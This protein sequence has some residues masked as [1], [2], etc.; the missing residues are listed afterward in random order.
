VETREDIR[1]AIDAA[2]TETTIAHDSQRSVK[3]G[4]PFGASVDAPTIPISM[5]PTPT[6]EYRAYHREKLLTKGPSSPPSTAT[7]PTPGP[8][9]GPIP[10]PLPVLPGSRTL[11][12]KQDPS[13]TAIGIRPVYL[14]RRPATGP[15][16]ARITSQGLPPVTA[17]AMGDFVQTPGTPDF[18]AV[19]TFTVVRQ[20]LT[21]CQRSL[22]GLNLPWQWNTGGNTDPLS[23][24]ARGF[25]GANAFYSRTQKALK[26]GFF[27]KPGAPPAPPPPQIFTCRS[28][29]IV[30]HEAGHAILDGLKPGWI[31]SPHPQT[32][33]LHEA[34]GDEMA[35]FL[36][37]AQLDQVEAI[38]VQ[39]K[40]NLHD[41][42]FLSDMA[43]EFGLAL[44]RPNGLRNADNNLKLSEVSTEVHAISQVMTGAV[45]DILADIF[46]FENNPTKRDDAAVLLEVAQYVF[47]LVL[48]AH[49]AAPNANATFAD[50][51]N[52]MLKIA[53]A[54]GKPAQYRTFI[55]NQFTR[56]EVVV[57]ATPLTGGDD[58]DAEM[59]AVVVHDSSAVGDRRR[60]CGTMKSP[61]FIGEAERLAEE[62]EELRGDFAANSAGEVLAHLMS[63]D[64]RGNGRAASP[65]RRR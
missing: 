55:R 29:D 38:I 22:G 25:S 15:R 30:A 51:A 36:A 16:D 8:I 5:L 41:K 27:P 44:G 11:I 4:V 53:A 60:C 18:D 50:V 1:A 47:S 34:F 10:L 45:Y 19:H 40:A 23:V 62:L 65:R 54:D 63:D 28:F 52:Q 12:W 43:E 64:A 20:A 7:G 21:H 31:T 24:S 39:T 61:E 9:P 17:N 49:I 2:I 13:V 33:G 37:L 56:R 42:T 3:I 59:M 14:P 32:G 58:D 57:A 46:E 35:I 26:F 48:R 6:A